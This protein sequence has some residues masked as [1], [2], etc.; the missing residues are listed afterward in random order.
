VGNIFYGTYY[1]MMFAI[2]FVV[3]ARFGARA[4]SWL[5]LAATSGLAVTLLAMGLNL[6]PIVNVASKWEFAGKVAGVSLVL[7]LV[8]MAIYWNG[9]RRS[10]CTRQS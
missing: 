1:L 6:L 10:S 9:T 5:K 2:P 7:N 4:G 8:G 3:G